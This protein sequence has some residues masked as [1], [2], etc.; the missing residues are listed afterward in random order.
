M[1]DYLETGFSNW[2][3]ISGVFNITPEDHNGIGF[4]SL[5]LV[6]IQDGAFVYVAPEDYTNVP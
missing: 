5:A 3:G 1:R 2:P 4:E 6:V